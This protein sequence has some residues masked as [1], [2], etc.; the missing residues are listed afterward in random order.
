M[1]HYEETPQGQLWKAKL[2]HGASL[3]TKARA[4]EKVASTEKALEESTE[5]VESLKAQLK[6][7]EE[8]VE[9]LTSDLDG[10][11]DK[12]KA[13]Q[14]IEEEHKE[15]AEDL[16]RVLG[17]AAAEEAEEEEEEV[18][19][20][21]AK[22]RKRGAGE[23]SGR[24]TKQAKPDM[25]AL[26][27]EG[28]E[29]HY[30]HNFR[31]KDELRGQVMVEAAADAGVACAEAFCIYMGWGGRKQDFVEGFPPKKGKEWFAV[32]QKIQEKKEKEELRAKQRNER[33]QAFAEY[34]RRS[35]QAQRAEE[36]QRESVEFQL[37]RAAK[38]RADRE[39]DYARRR[40][41]AS[42]S[43]KKQ[44]QSTLRDVG[45]VADGPRRRKSPVDDFDEAGQN[46]GWQK[47]C[48]Q[49]S[50]GEITQGEF[51]VERRNWDKEDAPTPPKPGATR[52]AKTGTTRASK[53]K[54]PAKVPPD[55]FD[56]NEESRESIDT[57]SA[58]DDD[59]DDDFQGGYQPPEK[60]K[61]T[62][63]KQQAKTLKELS[64]KTAAKK[65][66]GGEGAGK[67]PYFDQNRSARAP[68]TTGVKKNRPA[69]AADPDP[70]DVIELD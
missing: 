28:H 5:K 3:K 70:K 46:A 21:G 7:E 20:G 10:C 26:F 8:K 58:E 41:E 55:Q 22:K 33:E 69:A 15:E 52:A 17:K 48:D 37:L 9:D 27:V 32:M 24:A 56:Y 2:L 47:I 18:P 6:A 50:S 45:V 11:K 51:D 66:A 62:L 65:A 43:T 54:T 34:Q 57:D 53:R 31:K 44:R 49:Y 14:K 39:A 40:R 23:S 29:W 68:T 61:K 30:G 1:G 13:L 4:V 42:D 63:E 38:T 67:S 35:A 64:A 36:Q 16:E 59:E 12:P 19:G 60:R 25:G